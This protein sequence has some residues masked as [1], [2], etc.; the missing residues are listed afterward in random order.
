MSQQNH[1]FCACSDPQQVH[2]SVCVRNA[3]Q[4]AHERHA[5][6]KTEWLAAR[7]AC[8]NYFMRQEQGPSV[9][10]ELQDRSRK[11]RIELESLRQQCA[12][13]AL[14]TCEMQLK[15]EERQQQ[16]QKQAAVAVS[17]EQLHRLEKSIC[18]SN[19]GALVHAIRN[20]QSQARTLRFQWALRAFQMHRLQVDDD[21]G[22]QSRNKQTGRRKGQRNF[23]SG[24]G[25][26]GG[27][28]VPHAGPELYGVLPAEELQS[29]LRLVASL[30]CLAAR[31][32]GILLPHPILLHPSHDNESEQ[33]DIAGHSARNLRGDVGGFDRPPGSSD[34]L[35]HPIE[36]STSSISS[37]LQTGPL[38]RNSSRSKNYRAPSSMDPANVEQRVRHAASAII[39]E[40]R[41]KT[42]HYALSA[43]KMNQDE[44]AIA[45]QLLQND[46]I[47]LAIRAGVP[48]D[49]LWPGEAVLL[50]LHALELYCETQAL[51]HEK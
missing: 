50:N 14:Q 3:L 17:S 45:L 37:A 18:D 40:D 32:L 28:P 24:I 6:A 29:A 7:Q 34:F 16:Q 9:V 19:Q 48:V 38:S 43:E 35:I 23:V 44:F 26:I 39:A 42:T 27:L 49:K 1:Y 5:A 46:V 12:E 31:C 13:A 36:S 33:N 2:C 8:T 10:S 25:K 47:A 20:A 15:T 51:L 30:T 41:S 21:A 22:Q 4:A 11:L